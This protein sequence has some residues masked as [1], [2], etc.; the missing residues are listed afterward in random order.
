M[1]HPNYSTEE[2]VRR[3]EEIY[4]RDLRD[5]VEPQHNG[6]FLVLDIDTGQ[7][8]IDAD[9]MAAIQRAMARNPAGARYIKRIG[10]SAA[11]RLGGRFIAK[12]P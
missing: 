12:R 8:E 10:Y 9:E 7:F 11:H 5:K 3:G 6:K 1:S 4:E 2:V